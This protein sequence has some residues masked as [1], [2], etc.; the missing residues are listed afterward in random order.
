MVR[1]HFPLPFGVIVIKKNLQNIFKRFSYYIFIKIYGKIENSI[2]VK[3]DNRIEV[4][5][6]NIEKYP[7][8]EYK[9]Y[10]ILN[11]RLYTDRVQDIAVILDNKIVEGP[12]FQQRQTK[13]L[14]VYNA[15][16]NENIVFKKGTSRILRSLNGSI[17]SLLTGGGGN[18]NYWHWLFDVLPR[19]SLCSKVINL[20]KIDYFLL[21]SILNNFQN[22]TLNLLKIPNHKR[23]SSEKYRHV[24]S[25][26]LLVTDHPVVISG[27]AT[28][29][30]NNPPGWIIEW[31][32]SNFLKEGIISN[33]EQKKIYIDRTAK[34]SNLTLQ[35][36]ITNEEEVK[37]CLIK[38]NFIP[39]K[40]HEIKFSDQVDL[41]Y[42]AECVVGL[43]G[44]GFVNLVFCKPKTKIIEL[45]SLT[46]GNS[47]QNISKKNNL[48]YDPIIVESKK[49]D[50][51]SISNQQGSYKI[52]IN[53]L[54]EKIKNI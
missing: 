42:N 35:R 10:K 52:P 18:E 28:E 36:M 21:P 33:K 6:V 17:L 26:N 48:N 44:A 37:E 32:R 12:S 25:N 23:L 3:D 51:S 20:N 29:D 27:D 47:I 49:I 24:K 22:E 14:K 39:V 13:E 9:V 15:P 1:F 5:T 30:H 46:S 43:H 11:G 45:R 54:L 53:I 4:K 38:N 31:L 19:L 40:L 34:K 41:F 2:N 50:N 8:Y 16:I 7:R